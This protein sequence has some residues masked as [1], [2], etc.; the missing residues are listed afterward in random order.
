MKLSSIRTSRRFASVLLATAG[1]LISSV[2]GASISKLDVSQKADV[3]KVAVD[4]HVDAPPAQ[5]YAVVLA[6]FTHL[7]EISPDI[8]T[9]QLVKQVNART[10]VVYTETRGCVAIFCRTLRQMQ[11]V[12]E[13]SS[14]DIVAVTLPQGSNVKQGTSSWHLTAEGH[15]T[16]LQ[17]KATVEPAF[18]LPPFIGPALVRRVLQMQSEEFING[19]ERNV[20]DH[21]TAEWARTIRG[22]TI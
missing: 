6:D 18:W 7:V 17:W 8:F 2:W 21:R 5:V 19:I 4:A 3:Y 9:S 1:L 11:R 12:T 16:H 14:T 22:L 10:M 15:G 13:L 20:T